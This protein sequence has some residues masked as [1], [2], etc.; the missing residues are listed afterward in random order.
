MLT[1]TAH[2]AYKCNTKRNIF[3]PI[4][5]PFAISFSIY[6]RHQEK[7]EKNALVVSMEF[8]NIPVSPEFAHRTG[9]IL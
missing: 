3:S 1:E 9:A 5:Q 7:I 4:S 2:A 8:C 6:K